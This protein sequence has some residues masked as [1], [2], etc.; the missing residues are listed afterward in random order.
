MHI[1]IKYHKEIQ[2][3]L[4]VNIVASHTINLN[5]RDACIISLD[6]VKCEPKMISNISN[7]CANRAI[8]I[9]KI[10]FS[11]FMRKGGQKLLDS[12][13][14]LPLKLWPILH[15][16][17][18]KMLPRIADIVSFKLDLMGRAGRPHLL[19]VVCRQNGLAERK[20][21]RGGGKKKRPRA[22]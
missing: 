13:A 17:A 22:P 7:N 21:E 8:I 2:Q 14:T 11:L 12:L 3:I 6:C 1:F 5:V 10:K 9:I 19:L 18:I 15:G 16:V 4:R 20:R